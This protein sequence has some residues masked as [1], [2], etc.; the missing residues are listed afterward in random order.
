MLFAATFPERVDKLVLIEGGVPMIGTAED[1]PGTLAQALAD[2]RSLRHK[3]GRVFTSRDTAIAER[4]DGFSKVT[5]EAAGIL[6]RRSLRAVP[7]GFQWHAD[8]RLKGGSEIRLTA[9]HVRAF[10]GKV[11]APVL[12]FLSEQSP[13]SQSATYQEMISRFA[14]IEVVRLPGGHHFHLEGAQHAIAERTRRFFGLTG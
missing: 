13:F 10:V 5:T 2:R 1:A 9:E 6:A 12:M 14:H 7:G 11:A 8:Q 4:A 3:S